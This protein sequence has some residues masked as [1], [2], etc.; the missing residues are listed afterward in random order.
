MVT[1]IVTSSPCLSAWQSRL[2]HRHG[3]SMIV[4]CEP[5]LSRWY[6]LIPWISP[7]STTA[8]MPELPGK[9]M[10]RHPAIA[11][12]LQ[13]LKELGNLLK[14]PARGT[15]SLQSMHKK[16]VSSSQVAQIITSSPKR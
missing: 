11:N 1:I 10:A 13:K 15:R 2:S 14:A 5:I 16:T 12:L 4:F 8:D 9:F 3:R 7:T 6:S